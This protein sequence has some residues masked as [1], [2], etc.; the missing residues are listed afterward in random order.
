[1]ELALGFPVVLLGIL[2]VLQLVLVGRDQL[3]VTHAAREAARAAAV[4]P[5]AGAALRGAVAS[6]GTLDPRRL[7]VD[8]DRRGD[9]VVVTLRYRS[10]T[11]LPLVGILVP[12]PALVSTVT[13]R[14][15]TG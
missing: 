7:R 3:L 1:M 2:L 8:A 5:T 12:D 10:R 15:E 14:L 13:M 6:T 9:V 11:S 4:D